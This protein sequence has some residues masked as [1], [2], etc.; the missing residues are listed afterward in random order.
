[1]VRLFFVGCSLINWGFISYIILKYRLYHLTYQGGPDDDEVD[2]MHNERD[3][4][5][6][7]HEVE[8][9][10]SNINV[11]INSSAT[12]LDKLK[13]NARDSDKDHDRHQ[14]DEHTLS[15]GHGVNTQ[16]PV[17]VYTPADHDHDDGGNHSSEHP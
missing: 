15:T 10:L 1:M 2:L 6:N 17:H 12:S 9:T 16:H 5:M 4:S 8:Q 13:S 3:D 7:K 14:E 11:A